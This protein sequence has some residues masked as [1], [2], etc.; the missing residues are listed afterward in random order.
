MR[1]LSKS[2]QICFVIDGTN[3]MSSDIKRVRAALKNLMKMEI[4][5]E[6]A[7]IIYRDHDYPV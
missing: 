5:K 3:S 6:V 1:G 2:K 7:I 4:H